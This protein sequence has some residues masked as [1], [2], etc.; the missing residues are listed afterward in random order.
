MKKKLILPFLLLAF[1]KISYAQPAPQNHTETDT[2]QAWQEESSVLLKGKPGGITDNVHMNLLLRS[3]LELPSGAAQSSLKLNEA[4]FEVLGTIVPDLDFRVRWRLN[5]S[6][7]QRSLDN[8]P[9]SLD[10]AAVNYRFGKNK[11]WSVNVGKQAAYVGSWEFE[12]NPTYEYQYSE[13]INYQTNIFMMGAKLGYKINDN[14]SFHIQLHNTYNES[15]NNLHASTGYNNNGLKGSK[16]PMGVY[17]SWLGNLFDNKF[18]TFWSYNISQYAS[19]KTNHSI[20]LGNKVTFDKFKAYLDLQQTSLPVDY[21]NIASPSLNRYAQSQNPGVEP[22]FASDINY[23]SAILRM[24]Y[25][26]VP[27]WFVTAKGYYE[28]NSQTKNNSTIGKNFRENI[29]YLG[30][31]EYKPIASQNMKLFTYYYGSRVNYNNVVATANSNQKLNI[32]SAG[33]LYFVNAF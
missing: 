13:F 32:F 4:R 23:K 9:G 27:G 18:H 7:S 20:A 30:G 11:K 15:F 33:I 24:D 17:V 25:E 28:S 31:I 12:N 5:R 29:G 16:N 21:A 19:G 6:H 1:A 8:A 2:T 10:I 3:S 14:H 26:F 22:V